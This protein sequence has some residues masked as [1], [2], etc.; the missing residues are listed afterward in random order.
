MPASLMPDSSATPGAAAQDYSGKGYACFGDAFPDGADRKARDALA[1]LYEDF[2]KDSEASLTLYGSSGL[3]DGQA[4][5]DHP[6]LV[7][8]EIRDLA[9]HP[10]VAGAIQAVLGC[11]AAQLWYCHALRK[12]PRVETNAAVGWHFDGQ[13]SPFFTGGFITAWIPLTQNGPEGA[14]LI[15]V[16]RSHRMALPVQSG[17]SHKAS[18]EELKQSILENAPVDWVEERVEARM[19]SFVLHDSRLLHG[20][21]ANA[22][23]RPRLSLTCHYR[24]EANR[25]T[26]RSYSKF[27]PEDLSNETR[28]PVILGE[29]RALDFAAPPNV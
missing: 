27:R 17:F 8:A 19:N 18:L 16:A 6:H 7:S 5:I 10:R 9:T 2:P 12:P 11:R 1:A 28:C 14:P 20:S 24:T 22:S 4:R 23:A 15:Y 3:D 21:G 25:L 26:G 13:Y 29:R